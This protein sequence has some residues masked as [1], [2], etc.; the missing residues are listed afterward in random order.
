[1]STKKNLLYSEGDPWIKKGEGEPWDVTMGSWDGA[2]VCD[3]IGLYSLS[4]CQ[5]L[6]LNLGLYR[7]DGLAECRKRPQQVENV[8]KKLCQ[9]FRDMGLKISIE[10]N[11]KIVN[12][13]DI[14]L[15]LQRDLFKP[16]MKPNNTQ[17]Y[18]NKESNHPP[19]ILKNIP[20]SVNLRLSQLSKNEIVFKEAATTYQTALDTAGYN[21]KLKFNPTNHRDNSQQS[22][23]SK[24][25]K[26]RQRNVVFFNPPFSKTLFQIL[27]KTSSNSLTDLSPQATS[28]TQS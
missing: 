12:F 10:A 6:G 23:N 5:D 16:F 26:H 25:K 20:E 18:V 24:R 4:K 13:L 3:L 19:S 22:L 2:E 17:C 27:V 11:K 28:F 1:M 8:K 9:I 15:D 7:D 21:Y 14:T